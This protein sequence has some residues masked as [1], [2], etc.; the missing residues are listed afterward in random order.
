MMAQTSISTPAITTKKSPQWWSSL[1]FWAL[2]TLVVLA[3]I[4]YGIDLFKET[5][6][7]VAAWGMS[8]TIPNA[9]QIIVDGTSLSKYKAGYRMV[10]ICFHWYGKEDVQDREPIERS[11]VMDI[12][13]GPQLMPIFYDDTFKNE[14]AAGGHGTTYMLLIIPAPSANNQFSTLRQAYS[15]GAKPVWSAG[16]PP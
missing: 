1:Q 13:D 8:P 4:P 2:I 9:S 11:A 7:R 15:L 12:Q 16:G 6:A 14:V 10:A 5:P 3:W